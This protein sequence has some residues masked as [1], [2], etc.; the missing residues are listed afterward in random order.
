MSVRYPITESS[1]ISSSLANG[2]FPICVK[3]NRSIWYRSPENIPSYTAKIHVS[4]KQHHVEAYYSS[5]FYYMYYFRLL[6]TFQN[7]LYMVNLNMLNVLPLLICFRT[8]WMMIYSHLIRLSFST[9]L[10]NEIDWITDF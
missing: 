4:L 9:E 1:R 6:P 8:D 5:S 10:Y 2:F 3:I 7:R